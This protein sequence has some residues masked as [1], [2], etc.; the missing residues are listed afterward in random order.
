[1]PHTTS[2]VC[3]PSFFLL[4]SHFSS[5]CSLKSLVLP[6]L[7]LSALLPLRDESCPQC[8]SCRRQSLCRCHLFV[9]IRFFVFYPALKSNS[10]CHSTFPNLPWTW[11]C[12][13]HE[14]TT[15]RSC[16]A[17][18]FALFRFPSCAIA[19]QSFVLLTTSQ[20]HTRS[21]PLDRHMSHIFQS[22]R[23]VIALFSPS[24]ADRRDV[25]AYMP[26]FSFNSFYFRQ[27]LSSVLKLFDRR[28]F[29]RGVIR[30]VTFEPEEAISD[31]YQF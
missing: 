3:S 30:E 13:L 15:A 26:A 14:V 23:N 11:S 29:C 31:H 28:Q 22:A 4:L 20:C 17:L 24:F 10:S 1:M 25:W 9:L 27:F 6:A 5:S 21:P 12:C 8:F 19:I 16:V 18:Q 2:R 7:R